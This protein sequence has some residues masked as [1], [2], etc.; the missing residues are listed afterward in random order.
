MVYDYGGFPIEAGGFGAVKYHFG[1]HFW[2]APFRDILNQNLIATLPF[3]TRIVLYPTLLYATG[4]AV[5]SYLPKN[6][7]VGAKYLPKFLCGIDLLLF[8]N[9]TLGWQSE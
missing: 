8:I 4:F 6:L 5:L 3:L 2:P 9:E 7:L 1:L